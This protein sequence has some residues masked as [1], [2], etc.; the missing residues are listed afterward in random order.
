MKPFMREDPTQQFY[1]S[2]WCLI[3]EI[4]RLQLHYESV[5]LH[6]IIHKQGRN[7]FLAVLD[8]LHF[9]K[10]CPKSCE[11]SSVS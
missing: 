8:R 11:M 3:V 4:K 7:I 1:F 6:G 5:K 2:F 10:L 9:G